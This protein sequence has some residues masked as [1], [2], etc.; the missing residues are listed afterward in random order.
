MQQ[1]AAA[2]HRHHHH[3]HRHSLA[4]LLLSLLLAALLPHCSHADRNFTRNTGGT[5]GSTTGAGP[6]VLYILADSPGP[7][8]YPAASRYC[9]DVYGMTVVVYGD[10]NEQ[11]DVETA[12][13]AQLGSSSYWTGLIL[14]NGERHRQLLQMHCSACRCSTAPCTTWQALQQLGVLAALAGAGGTCAAGRFRSCCSR[15]GQ[16]LRLPLQRAGLAPTRGA[17]AAEVPAASLCVNCHQHTLRTHTVHTHCAYTLRT[18]SVP[19]PP[20]RCHLGQG[21][22][23]VGGRCHNGTQRSRRLRQLGAGHA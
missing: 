18:H 17:A 3:H 16:Q 10:N 7:L 13:Q 20:R 8:S 23:Q 14:P 22:L 5:G 19:P 15:F 6:G 11:S 12:F 21:H 1:A 4:A 2:A 9:D